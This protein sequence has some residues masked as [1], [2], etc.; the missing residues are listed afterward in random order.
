MRPLRIL[1][2]LVLLLAVGLGGVLAYDRLTAPAPPTWEPV[3]LPTALDDW[4]PPWPEAAAAATAA[5]DGCGV[6]FPDRWIM[7]GWD[8]ADW[9][10]ILPLLEAGE[11]PHFEALMRSGSYGELASFQPSL[12][13]AI[14]TTVATGVSPARHGIVS[15]YN[16][17]PRLERWLER[18]TH[19][20][21]L[22]R[23]LYSNADRRVRSV[24]NIL[25]EHDRSVLVVGYHNTFPAEEV[26]GMMVSNYLFQDSTA[27]LMQMRAGDEAFALSLVSPAR[28]LPEVLEIQ[29]EVDRSVVEALPR[30]A[31]FEDERDLRDFIHRARELDPDGDQRPYFLQRAW[32][33]D[34]VVAEIA[35]RYLPEIEPELAMVHFQSLDWAAHHFLYFHRPELFAEMEWS[36]E[37]RRQLE[38]QLPRYRDT[39]AAFYRYMDGWL[40]RLLEH[41]GDATGVLLLSDHGVGAGPDPDVPGNH[42]HA[43]PGIVVLAGPGIRAGHRIEGATVYDVLP[44]LLATLGLPV[45][46]DLEGEVLTEALCP[47]ALAANEPATVASYETGERY[48]PEVA[49]PPELQKDLV[50]QLESLGYLQ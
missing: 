41:R 11:L 8:A 48:V 35:D 18:L 10:W 22:D 4:R 49:R 25:S 33:F 30:F 47:A 44:T 20:G 17:K 34:T 50:D 38:A 46:E 14:W 5:D 21:E 27:E 37:V 32:A 31:H 43:P 6:H 28:H 3:H 15:F 26:D 1:L 16:Q 36:P 39:V 9:R 7:I 24:W 2:I 42:D 23:D 29:E 40:G 19:F 45:A 13:P 12:S